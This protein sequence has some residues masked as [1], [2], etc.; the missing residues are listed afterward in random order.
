MVYGSWKGIKYTRQ[1]VI[2]ANP[3]TTAQQT[4]RALFKMLSDFW[5]IAPSVIADTWNAQAKGQKY[6]GRNH[7]IG[8][9]VKVMR[10]QSD[11]SD[12]IG[13]PG[14]LSGFPPASMTAVNNASTDQ[15]DVTF[16]LQTLPTGWTATSVQAIAFGDQDDPTMFVGPIEVGSA[17]P[18][19][20]AVTVEGLPRT[21]DN[22]V[23]GW[24]TY[25]RP[26]GKTCYGPSIT[27]VAPAGS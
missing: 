25:T 18:P 12:F 6:A 17:T 15:V 8:Q 13:S 11:L 16:V 21:Q 9:N 20:F 26:D 24:V 7:F 14:N 22:V 3:N 5:T 27:T 4:T 23:S 19:T 2:P 10:G 1:H